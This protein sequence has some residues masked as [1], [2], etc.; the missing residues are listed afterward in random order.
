M[1]RARGQLAGL[2]I[3]C[4]SRVSAA[5]R[6]V[7]HNSA[8]W[9]SRVARSD[10]PPPILRR[11]DPLGA[12]PSGSVLRIAPPR[13]GDSS[14]RHSAHQT[15]SVATARSRFH[16]S[17]AAFARAATIS[18]AAAVRAS[19]RRRAA[20]ATVC[21]PTHPARPAGRTLA[22]QT[23]EPSTQVASR[24]PSSTSG[25]QGMIEHR[26][27]LIARDA[28]EPFQKLIN[29]GAGLDVLEQRFHRH[30]GVPEKARRR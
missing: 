21:G 25:L 3:A 28:V 20:R 2:W 22:T 10:R 23:A 14:G 30:A 1:R 17:S 5:G 24:I 9:R 13:V 6:S 7:P 26:F 18:C 19:S 15:G 11:S 4:G 12:A 8:A 27:H 29:R 16:T